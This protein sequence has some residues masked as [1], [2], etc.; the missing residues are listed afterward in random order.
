MIK[1][2]LEK[3][4]LELL[5]FFPAVG[6]IGPRQSGK[7]T[8]ARMLMEKYSKKSIYL[9]LESPTDRNK[10]TEPEYFFKDNIDKCVVL[11]EIQRMPEL[12]PLLR[13]SIDKHKIPGRFIILGSANP[14]ILKDSSE[15]LTGRIAYQELYPFNIMET[16]F[17]NLKKHWLR[18]GFPDA[19]KQ[20]NI[21]RTRI[22]LENFVTTYI[23]RDLPVIGLDASSITLANFWSM[24]AHNHG[25]I[26]N[27]SNFARS[28][29]VSSPT[30][31]RYLHFLEEAFLVNRLIPF[32]HNTRKRLVK[33]PKVYIR[34]SGVLHYLTNSLDPSVLPLHIIIGASWEGYVVE[35][36]KQ[37]IGKKLGMFYYRTHQGTEC[38][39]VLAKGIKSLASIEIKYSSSPVITRSFT[40]AIEDLRTKDNFI[41][42][43]DCDDYIIR[44]NIKVCSLQ[45][46]LTRHLQE[47]TSKLK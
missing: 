7:T 27:A 12:F 13:S 6:I 9:D 46:F 35:Q 3:E 29:G 40:Q 20:K 44:D 26:F 39:L 47:I 24:L 33:S 38:D 43:P 10:L 19:Y 4:L 30:V 11:D 14:A 41:I 18:G 31:T 23:E 8:L 25:N 15:A 22:W 28:L 45:T 42:T 32:Y 1:R 36:V 21:S 2:I 37:I 5:A 16:G 34:D 17:E